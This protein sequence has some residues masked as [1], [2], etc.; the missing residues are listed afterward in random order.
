LLAPVIWCYLLFR[1]V[2]APEY[3]DGLTQ[4]LGFCSQLTSSNGIMVHCASVGETVAAVPLIKQ[5]LQAYPEISITVTSTTP[6]GK[7]T[8]FDNFGDL[9]NHSYLPIDWPS[10][11]QRFLKRLKPQLVVLMETELW[12]NFLHACGTRNIPVLLANARLSDKSLNSYLKYPKLTTDLFSNVTMVAAQFSS[13]KQNFMTL[14][15]SSGKLE[16]TGSI[17]FDIK[18]TEAILSQQQQLKLQWA[19]NRPVWVAASIHPGEFKTVLKAHKFLLKALPDA[20]LVAIPRHPEKF[21]E[22]KL[23]CDKAE[24]K[25]ISRTDNLIPDENINIVVGDTM[26]EMALFCG[27]ADM[28]FVG[29]SLIERGGHNPLEPIAC[30][31]P[32]IMG[33]HYF[34]FSDVC[35]ILIDGQLLQVAKSDDELALMIKASLEDKKR[36]SELSKKATRIIQHNSGCVDKMMAQVKLLMG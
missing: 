12:P 10:S 33:P 7:K 29:G 3:R 6:T 2:K 5:L 17:K 22:L 23:A 9:V 15:V 24:F 31:T 35:K 21:D 30:G 32:V 25:F 4:R 20:L 16:I 13:D 19:K 27:I 26:G 28:A 36:L 18:I 8:V 14:G 34:N 1:A 11:C